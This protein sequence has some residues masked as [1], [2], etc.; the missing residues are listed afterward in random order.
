M[1]AALLSL[2]LSTA[3]CSKDII[4]QANRP[5]TRSIGLLWVFR[6]FVTRNSPGEISCCLAFYHPDLVEVQT[7][8]CHC[9]RVN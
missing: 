6:L 1:L 5:V 9:I 3:S 7:V 2:D 8:R 4:E